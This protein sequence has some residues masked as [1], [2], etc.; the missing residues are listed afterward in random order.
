VAPG[1]ADSGGTMGV[2]G[3]ADGVGDADDMAL[4]SRARPGATGA[5]SRTG[6]GRTRWTGGGR[7]GA[8]SVAGPC[9]CP[10]HRSTTAGPLHAGT[11]GV[12]LAGLRTRGH[13]DRV[14]VATGS[15]LLSAASQACRLA[16]PCPV[17]MAE[18]VPAYRC[19]GSPGF[20]PDSLLASGLDDRTTSCGNTISSEL[21][22]CR[23]PDVVLPA[24]NRWSSRCT[25]C[26][27]PPLP[28]DTCRGPLW[29]A[30]A[31]AGVDGSQENPSPRRGARRQR[32]TKRSA[33]GAGRQLMRTTRAQPRAKVG[34]VGDQ[35]A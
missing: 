31:T 26:G 8:G 18:V 34:D 19:G 10:G 2:G 28:V 30:A 7:L 20:T 27:Q 23:A 22:R 12:Q 4:S 17:L 29:T 9:A 13:G 33:A 11:R 14:A 32:P 3:D 15:H 16:S 5:R 6:G 25:A 35:R 24:R 1:P 21:H